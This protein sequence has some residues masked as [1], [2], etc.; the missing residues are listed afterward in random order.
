MQSALLT[1]LQE[2]LEA[3][4]AATDPEVLFK[5]WLPHQIGNLE[6]LQKFFWQQFATAASRAAGGGAGHGPDRE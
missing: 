2:R 5:T 1:Q 4:L 3:N 6:Q